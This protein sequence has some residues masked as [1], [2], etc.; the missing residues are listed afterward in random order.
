MKLRPIALILVSVLSLGAIEEGTTLDEIIAERGEPTSRIETGDTIFLNYSG[1][2]IKL[3]NGK[4]VSVKAP[5]KV[6]PART[7]P[8]GWSTN[9][10]SAVAQAKEENRRVFL[11]FT[12]S[13]WSTW[14]KR[15]DREII[16]T[17]EFRSYAEKK[18]IL[19]K[20][21]FP[22]ELS[23]PPE[24]VEQNQNLRQKYRVE[25]YPTIIVLDN[26]AK[27]LGRLSYMPGGPKPF[28]NQLKQF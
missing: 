9:Y 25:G 18:L 8:G 22:H 11:L 15:F 27:F 14:C 28:L 12:G 19:V 26:N 23:Q 2:I 21:D 3:T 20:L 16:A 17:P 5:P 10:T 24:V 7:E 4:V 13:D 6:R 1:E